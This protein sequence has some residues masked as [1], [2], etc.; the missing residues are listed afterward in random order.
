MN[1]ILVTAGASGIGR[2]I[3]E[4][5][6]KDGFAVHVCD[7]NADHIAEFMQ[8]NPNAT[9]SQTDVSKI[10]DVPIDDWNR[11]IDVNLNGMFYVTKLAVPLL[12]KNKSGSIVNLSSTAGLMGVPNR[13]PYTASKWAVVGLTKTLAMELGPFNINVNAVCPGCVE[14][15]RIRRVIEADAK[16]QGKTSE[17][18]EAVYKR[19]SSMRLF[20]NKD[21]VANMVHYLSTDKGHNLS[22]QAI[23][24][25]GNTE[26]LFNWLEP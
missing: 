24:V 26:G 18:I 20:V 8:N 17:E 7:I 15:D 13:S 5:F 16:N 21:D 4:L 9:A 25:D 19:Q 23:A 2:C 1:V 3:A 22:G 11:T 10:E 14:G 12:K 6:L